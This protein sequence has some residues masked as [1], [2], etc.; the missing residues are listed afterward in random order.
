M[1]GH[2]HGCAALNPAARAMQMWSIHACGAECFAIGSERSPVVGLAGLLQCGPQGLP[3]VARAVVV[4][5]GQVL[6]E[7]ARNDEG[8]GWKSSDRRFQSLLYSSRA[9]PKA[10]PPAAGSPRHGLPI[11]GRTHA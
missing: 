11:Q 6:V 7:V 4:P 3:L 8:R 9:A 2:L 1:S 5:S 10:L